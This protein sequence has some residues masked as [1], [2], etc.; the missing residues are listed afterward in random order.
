[1]IQLWR[2]RGWSGSKVANL[3]SDALQEQTESNLGGKRVCAS[4]EVFVQI[5]KQVIILGL[6]CNVP[7][8]I[9]NCNTT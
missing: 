9:A 4:K 6:L 1:M 8:V 3:K 7:Q 5:V 2:A